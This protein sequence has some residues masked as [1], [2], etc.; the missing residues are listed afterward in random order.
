MWEGK[1]AY[2]LAQGQWTVPGLLYFL[3]EFSYKE[4]AS[5]RLRATDEIESILNK[6]ITDDKYKNNWFQQ[7][8]Y[9]KEEIY[10]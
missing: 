9:I 5:K 10:F 8:L 1:K 4:I 7:N 6:S 2:S 3:A